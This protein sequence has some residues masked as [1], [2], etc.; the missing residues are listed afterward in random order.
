MAKPEASGV[1]YPSSGGPALLSE[2]LGGRA[3]RKETAGDGQ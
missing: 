2:G 3:G 1:E